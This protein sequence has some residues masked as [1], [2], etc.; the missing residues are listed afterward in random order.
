MKPLSEFWPDARKPR[1]REYTCASCR[2]YKLAERRGRLEAPARWRRD[3][4]PLLAA[5]LAAHLDRQDAPPLPADW[6][7][8][9]AITADQWAN[10]MALIIRGTRTPRALRQ[11]GI[12]HVFFAGYLRHSPRL[13][14]RFAWAKRMAKRRG[15]PSA[16]ELDE[17]FE[18][19]LTP[20]VSAKQACRNRGVSYSAFLKATRDPEVE[21]RYLAAKGAQKDRSFDEVLGD[22]SGA[23][24]GGLTRKVRRGINQRLLAIRKLEPRRLRPRKERSPIEEARRRARVA[25]Q[26]R[27]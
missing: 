18:D 16:L 3:L 22:L 14:E 27:S 20:G 21:Q 9:D 26:Q 10:A 25:Q 8:A 11:A 12:R 17:I 24:D 1:G 23:A 5:R 6:T 4:M 2:A 15:W 7:G 13:R 19:L